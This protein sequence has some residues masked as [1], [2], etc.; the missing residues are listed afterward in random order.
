MSWDPWP[1]PAVRAAV[2][3]QEC[4]QIGKNGPSEPFWA[5]RVHCCAARCDASCDARSGKVPCVASLCRPETFSIP[6]EWEAS[7]G[8]QF[9]KL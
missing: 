4:T 2:G 1:R 6:D 8:R 7:H 5:I 9:E 3:T